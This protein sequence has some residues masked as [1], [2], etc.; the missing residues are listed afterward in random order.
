MLRSLIAFCLSR[1]LLVMVAFA[2]F[3][4]HRQ[5]CF[6][7]PE[8]RGLS[9][10]GAADHRDHRPAGRPVAG[11]SRALH[12]DSDRDRGRQH[13]R[14]EVHPLQHRLRTGLYPSAVRIR[15]RL[16]FR[17]SADH[18]PAEGCGSA[19]RRP[20]GDLA[21]RRHQRNLSLRAYRASG[22]GRHEAQDAA[23]LGGRTQAAHR[24]GC[25]RRRRARR[26][27]QGVPGR[28]QSRPHDG[29]WA[30]AAADH[31]RDFG[32]QFQCRRPHHR[33]RRTIGQCPQHRRRHLDGRHRQYRIDPAGRRAGT[34]VRR[35]QGPDRLRAPARSRRP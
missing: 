18:Q 30:D 34:G 10:S 16:S 7:G 2:A 11:G 32:E 35:S 17:S 25:R 5:R 4:G 1:R 12:H 28:D 3:L 21:R 27:D 24:A 19:G 13:A 20:A 31:D 23:G 8:H 15:P 14:P 26:K 9:R 22:H 6:P 33:D 29:P